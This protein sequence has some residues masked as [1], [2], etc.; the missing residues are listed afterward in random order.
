MRSGADWEDEGN[1]GDIAVQTF[2]ASEIGTSLLICLHFNFK[3]LLLD[4]RVFDPEGSL[5]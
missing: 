1:E 5:S 3:L 4:S 2:V